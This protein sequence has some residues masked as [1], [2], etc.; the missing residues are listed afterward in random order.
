MAR[1]R[2]TDSAPG[3]A[4]HEFTAS[5]DDDA[6]AQAERKARPFRVV[7]MSELTGPTSSRKVELL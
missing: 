4:W 5:D 3:L 7:A 2:M 6:R 1:Y